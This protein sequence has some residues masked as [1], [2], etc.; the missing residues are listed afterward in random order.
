MQVL[1][2]PDETLR[3]VSAEVQVFD[4]LLQFLV[5][6]MAEQMYADDGVG[7]AAPQVG[8]NKRVILVDPSGGESCKEFLVMVNPRIVSQTGKSLSFEGCLSLPGVRGEVE[9]FAE[10]DV[11]YQ[12]MTGEKQ[13]LHSVGKQ[14]IIIQHEVDHLDGVLF[15][16]KIKG[17]R[18]LTMRKTG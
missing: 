7:L 9:R 4:S 8:I 16:D 12:T 6:E 17:I 15:I 2:Y 1:K 10:I 11:E 13:T 3:I 14:A 18:R 5:N